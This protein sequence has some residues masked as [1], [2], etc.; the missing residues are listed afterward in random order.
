MLLHELTK[1]GYTIF[2]VHPSLVEIEG[3]RCFPDIKALPGHV[4]NLLLVVKP[5]TTAQIIH[6][7]KDSSIQ[8]VWLHKGAGAGS[9][10]EASLEACK[11]N[12][13]EVVHGFCPMMFLSPSGIHS[14]HFWLR[15]KFGKVPAGFVK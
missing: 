10:S 14:F 7:L 9:G 12:G 13:I 5:Q 4:T 15:K 1:K 2:P 8:R 11:G 6:E 3:V